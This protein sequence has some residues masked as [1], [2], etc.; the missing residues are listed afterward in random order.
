[1]EAGYKGRIKTLGL[2][3]EFISHGTPAEQKRYC[4]LDEDSIYDAAK[5]LLGTKVEG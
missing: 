4:G 3:D 2:P 5:A 1:M